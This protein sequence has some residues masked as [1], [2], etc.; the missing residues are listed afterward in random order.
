MSAGGCLGAGAT[1][2]E[3]IDG[4]I[5]GELEKVDKGESPLL[6]LELVL[7]LVNED[8]LPLFFIPLPFAYFAMLPPDSLSKLDILEIEFVFSTSFP[9]P[10]HFDTP[11]SLT[12]PTPKDR[13]EECEDATDAREG[14]FDKVPDKEGGRPTSRSSED[15]ELL[16]SLR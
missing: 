1:N 14:R 4:D 12:A 8:K 11:P 6:E 9:L 7:V 3:V 5:T 13:V 2:E 16:V 15:L 10:F